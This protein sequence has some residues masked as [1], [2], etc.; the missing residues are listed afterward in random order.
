M[1]RDSFI[2]LIRTAV[3]GLVGSLIGL[4]A[5]AGVHLNSEIQSALAAALVSACIAGY[6]A[7]ALW[8]ER[9]VW[10]GFGWLL[11]YPATP[12]YN[13]DLG[14]SPN[15]VVTPSSDNEDEF[16]MDPIENEPAG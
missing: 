3:P 5:L 13:A 15:V 10:S 8:L 9:N 11:G 1:L 6:Y 7:G 4:L 16:W 2:A 12:S 14:S